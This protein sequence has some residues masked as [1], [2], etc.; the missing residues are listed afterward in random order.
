H[1]ESCRAPQ[2]DVQA[3]LRSSMPNAPRK[4]FVEFPPAKC[5]E[6]TASKWKRV[7]KN[8]NCTP[9]EYRLRADAASRVGRQILLGIM[10]R[11]LTLTAFKPVIQLGVCVRRTVSPYLGRQ[12]KSSNCNTVE[13]EAHERKRHSEMV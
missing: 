5:T 6:S 10:I 13:K 1:P 11:H 7:R 12:G 8:S 2:I 3:T 4:I 9:L